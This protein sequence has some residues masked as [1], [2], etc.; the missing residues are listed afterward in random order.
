MSEPEDE[1]AVTKPATGG[2]VGQIRVPPSKS[3]TQRALV[4]A[5]LAGEGSV[6]CRPLDAEDPRLLAAALEA[7]GFG[8]RWT[9]ETVT[10]SRRETAR[11]T[12]LDLG[13]NGTGVRFL[14]AQLA[15]RP[16]RW[17]LDGTPR[18]RERPVAGLVRALQE[19]GA[20]IRGASAGDPG[21][22]AGRLPLLL[23]GR[24]LRGGEVSLDASA[25]S[26]FV[27]ALM[28]LGAALPEGVRITLTARPPS[29]PYLDLT[30]EVLQAFG[31]R[32]ELGDD[33]AVVAVQGPLHPTVLEIEGDWSAAAF[34]LAA[35]AV[36]GGEVEVQG[37]REGSRQGDSLVLRLLQAAGCGVRWGQGGVSVT[38]PAQR[39][40]EADL[41]DTPDLFPALAVVVACHGGRL[42]GL[43][44]LRAK[45]SDRLAVM[46]DHLTMLG[47][48]VHA[49]HGAFWS[50]GGTPG[51]AYR[52]PALDPAA[53]H[54]VA[55]ADAVAARVVPG[56]LLSDATCVRKSWPG[57]WSAWRA[58]GAVR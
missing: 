13:N 17:V 22:G 23:H 50:H 52:G 3:L 40:V 20:D 53:D 33:L 18:L 45:E 10:V 27:S 42:T 55:M 29:R 39:G 11:R 46:A 38:G 2:V 44:G 31:A 47:F 35:V 14:L 9:G 34:P 7:A 25:S 36:A 24:A 15:A 30:T 19:L 1:V 12:E 37:V 8:V 58:L 5:A 43:E 54:R 51:V 26:Q 56:V 6:V 32:V 57:F 28:L 41:G 16:G 21:G 49:G 4:A 48:Q